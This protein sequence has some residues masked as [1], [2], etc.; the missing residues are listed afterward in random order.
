MDNDL[1]T[2][3]TGGHSGISST[4]DD[5]A[6]VQ[7][8]RT[9]FIARFIVLRESKRTKAHRRIEQLSWKEESTAEQL[10]DLFREIFVE[11]GDNLE[12]VDRD[13]RR[14]LAHASRS[15]SFFI[16]EYVNRATLNFID[17]LIDYE[18]SNTLLFGADDQPKPGGWRLPH[19]LLKEK[20]NE[21]LK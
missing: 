17:A 20:R 14:A 4:Y 12:F 19:E 18:K 11:N 5:I 21:S 9:A 1:S 6:L 8:R 10:H 13:L 7:A 2:D 16:S 3:I 15:I